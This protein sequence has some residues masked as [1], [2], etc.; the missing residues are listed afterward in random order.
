MKCK[1]DILS[2]SSQ[3]LSFYS[4][5]I[6][7]FKFHVQNFEKTH[8]IQFAATFLRSKNFLR[9]HDDAHG[10]SQPPLGFNAVQSSLSALVISISRFL[11]WGQFRKLRRKVHSKFKVK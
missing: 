10:M 5:R 4:R 2:L 3:I 8:K 1:L 7:N 9:R 11:L 6:T